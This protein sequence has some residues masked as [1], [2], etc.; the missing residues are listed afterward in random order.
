MLGDAA[1]TAREDGRAEPLQLGDHPGHLIRRLQ[2]A[3]KLLWSKNVEADLTSSQFAV[4]NVLQLRP[5]IDQKTLGDHVGMDRTTIG[6]IVNRLVRAGLVVKIRDFE[7]TRRNVLRLSPRGR[8]L[9]FA[10]LPAASTVSEQ[11][12]ADL[13][14]RD[15]RELLRILNILVRAH[16]D[17]V[18]P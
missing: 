14:E 10:T 2:Q 7:D 4:L 18:D 1:G 8:D 5:N 3:H 11:L 6:Q 9:L 12:I 15:R 17:P 16:H 13:D